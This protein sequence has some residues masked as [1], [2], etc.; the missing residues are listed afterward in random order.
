MPRKH[1][2]LIAG[3]LLA[4][5]GLTIPAIALAEDAAANDAQA[6]A[7]ETTEAVAVADASGPENGA[8]QLVEIA[9]EP[10]PEVD[11]LQEMR[12]EQ[13]RL[14]T[15]YSLMMQRQKNEMLK[16]ELEKQRIQTESSFRSMQQ[17]EE[18]A[19]M[20]AEM[21]R[22]NVEQQYKR[23][24][25][26]AQLAAM[27]REIDRIN[28][29]KRHAD[30]LRSRELDKLRAESERLQAEAGLANARLQ[31]VRTEM[32][33][34]QTMAQREVA[35]IEARMTVLT[36]KEQAAKKVLDDIDYPLDPFIDG[37]LYISDRRVALNGPIISGTADWIT[38]RIHYFNNQSSKKPIFIVIDDC[39]GGSV[40]EGYRIVKAMEES[41]APVHVLVKSYAASMAAVITTLADH[42]YAYPNAIILHHQ[43][44]SGMRGNLTQQKEQLEESFEWA[45]RLAVPVAE[46]MGVSYERM[47]EM[48][49]E[50]NS[51]GDWAEFA[52]KAVELK[53][54]N[55]IVDEVREQNI[56][57]AP[58]NAAPSFFF[59]FMTDPESASPMHANM[60]RDERGNPFIQ[61][62]P[63]RP[64]D[65]YAL[66][67][68]D[69]FYRW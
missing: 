39:P 28:A 32:S 21:E 45:R 33:E 59:W 20:R 47:V 58:N 17:N 26:E 40:M 63:L 13:Q 24:K 2:T 37:T 65:H 68:P 62:P 46:K 16:L 56:R 54:V 27:Q 23:S 44:S 41:D 29:E 22:M 57:E 9:P 69:N 8:P 64:F 36:T 60:Q 48:M 50:N 19:E 43:M 35:E 34:I 25:Q 38:E 10:E 67:N 7:V 15:E 1:T 61:L 30:T 3:S 14:Q 31:A 6:E 52:D 11:P 42:S 12:E 5:A 49:Y 51:D 53:W 4:A 55:N 18:L 66:H